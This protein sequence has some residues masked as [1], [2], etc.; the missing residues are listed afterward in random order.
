MFLSARDIVMCVSRLL[1][2]PMTIVSGIV[3]K[4]IAVI[5]KSVINE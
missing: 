1:L 3:K 5:L 4:V 2:P